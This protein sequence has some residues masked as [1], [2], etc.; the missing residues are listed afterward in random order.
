[1]NVNRHPCPRLFIFK[2]SFW[3]AAA[4]SVLSQFALTIPALAEGKIS[5]STAVFPVRP[6]ALPSLS[7][8]SPLAER[9]SA[10]FALLP[11]AKGG[12]ALQSIRHRIWSTDVEVSKTVLP[13]CGQAAEF[14][15]L[16]CWDMTSGEVLA[17][18]PVPGQ[19]TTV[20]QFHDGS[21]YVG[22]SRGFFIRMEANGPYLT[23]SFGID[24]QFFHGPDA[25]AVMKSLASA[26]SVS[27]DKSDPLL[28][29]FKGGFRTSWQWYA[30][31]NAEFI[32]TPQFG[33]GQVFVLTANQSLNAFDLLT[34]KLNWSIRIAP[35]VQLRLS[36]TS[37]L[38][39]EKGVLVGTSDG[40][41]LLIEPK[42]GQLLW[43]QPVTPNPS[44]RFP[45]VVALALPLADGVVVANAESVTQKLN[46]NSRAVDW[47][48]A[49]GSV[50]QPKFD[51]GAVYIAGSDGAVHKLD[52]AT[53]QLRWR[54]PLPIST[55]L[56]AITLL[57]KQDRLLV[58]SSDG[59]LFALRMTDGGR[60]GTGAA[61]NSGPVLGDFFNGR[62][63]L[64]EVCLSYQTT[65]FACWNWS[66]ASRMSQYG[67]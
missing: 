38:L 6:S 9:A 48:Y 49:T 60:E 25:R 16:G 17:D 11:V 28:Q 61:S 4:L 56:M 31:A 52:A 42:S 45:S 19:L 10:G 29:S 63:E 30:T 21:W 62:V 18:I 24:S 40:Y 66:P 13:V 20:P 44:D 22:T 47:S 59:S 26:S 34:G 14:N 37:L 50:V 36:T 51:E 7:R 55:P 53:G 57:K 33:F 27:K 8:L 23:P 41:L 39:H 35:E 1:M 67:Q 43:R 58:A 64:N 5:Q 54:Q 46:W 3:A 65:G 2:S 32:G 15:T 12:A